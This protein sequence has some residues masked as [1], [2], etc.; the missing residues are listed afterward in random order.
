MESALGAVGDPTL[1]SAHTHVLLLRSLSASG[2]SDGPFTALVSVACGTPDNVA[3]I[4]DATFVFPATALFLWQLPFLLVKAQ[5]VSPAYIP[6]EALR[7]YWPFAFIAL[8]SLVKAVLF[9]GPAAYL[10]SVG[11]GSRVGLGTAL[12][13]F[14]G[15]AV[16]TLHSIVL[17]RRRARTE[18]LPD[19]LL[20][21]YVLVLG[22]EAA[23]AAH[24]AVELRDFPDDHDLRM[25]DVA[26]IVGAGL[27]GVVAIPAVV[28]LLPTLL[29]CCRS[30]RFFSWR[31]KRTR[32][33]YARE[34]GSDSTAASAALSSPE[35]GT[36]ASRPSLSSP[37][38]GRPDAPSDTPSSAPFDE[39]PLLSRIT[40]WWMNALM[41][42]GYKRPLE[43]TDVPRL[44]WEDEVAQ[45]SAG[46]KSAWASVA[47]HRRRSSSS[48]GSSRCGGWGRRSR[49]GTIEQPPDGVGAS[50]G[51]SWPCRA[52]SSATSYV[53]SD[54][55]ATR[56]GAALPAQPP[57]SR[58]LFVAFGSTF[59]AA[60]LFKLSFDTLQFSGPVL[61][62]GI[63]SFLQDSSRNDDPP[64]EW[65]GYAY[66]G[67]L[68]LSSLVQT[69]IL[70]AYFFRSF[71]AGQQ[72]R[73][74]VIASV[75]EKALR[76]SLTAR[77][78]Q[79]VGTI[80]NLMSTDAKRLQDLSSYLLTIIS[81]PYQIALAVVL[82]YQQIG[83]SVM[84]GV[85]VILLFIPLNA[86]IARW[87]KTL[88]T[89]LMKMKDSRVSLT[90]EALMGIRLIKLN[91]W[92]DTFLER[93]GAI[94]SKELGRLIIY[95]GVQQISNVLWN[96]L[97]L[98]VMLA[99]FAMYTLLNGAP[100][101]ASALF[102][103]VAL[104][105]LLRF[106]MTMI[107]QVINNGELGVRGELRA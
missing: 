54:G 32:G 63:I 61:L 23:T 57:L 67:L 68:L 70:H 44:S 6:F 104:F 7:G 100:P 81:G 46:F 88:Q 77:Q 4:F 83:V 86:V 66:T 9:A 49:T 53:I 25:L 64:P 78:G 58:V 29:C 39:A 27:A 76:L 35:K 87:S 94:R 5:A 10:F 102:T 95:T 17:C 45:V 65:I 36:S 56:S 93:I 24:R 90:N 62:S 22:A 96:G 105:N 51:C 99:A 72:M 43:M 40:F 14:S 107:P 98:L 21:W 73:S 71:R 28:V 20:W 33:V 59:G 106:P 42:R 26:S 50:S 91:G 92:E 47:G 12:A 16:W 84:G 15:A 69:S 38:L 89:S 48:A 80:T 8:I 30:S 52:R 75:Y 13:A 2:G 79:S 37:L 82:L 34:T 1:A 103:S 101:S 41:A 60:L 97:P 19:Y 55:D 31:S 11:H 74:A 18:P 85:A 3:C